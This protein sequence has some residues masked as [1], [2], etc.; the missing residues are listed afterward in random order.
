MGTNAP[1]SGSPTVNAGE[2]VN[3]G[4]EFMLSYKENLGKDF[5]LSASVNATTLENEVTKVA[6]SSGFVD[7]GS[8]GVGQLLPARMEVGYPIG[9]F[10]GY[11]TDGIF[12]N[13]AETLQH[14]SQLALGAEASPG[15]FRYKDL[16]DDG[17]INDKDR[18]SLG[19]PIPD[20]T[21]GINLSLNYK[22]FDFL[23]YA[24]ASIG[25]DIIRNYE[26]VQVRANKL[27]YYIE[28]W[29]GEGTS[30]SI[31]RLTTRPTTNNV[32]SD[33]FVEDGSFL[34]LQTVQLGYTLSETLSNKLLLDKVR[35]SVTA[36]NLVTLTKYKGFDPAASNGAPIGSGIDN[37]FY[38]IPTTLTAAINLKF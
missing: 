34:R 16:N 11:H 7:G 25:H 31:P 22:R 29:R 24:F 21:F 36:E 6:N 14:P 27:N 15:D 33:F 18:A 10:L 38:P 3:K 9:Y 4:F 26:R 28:R 35:V 37:G 19:D 2:V 13:R 12:Q 17:V 32:L 5:T 23:A 20:Y 8:F 30:N 1:G